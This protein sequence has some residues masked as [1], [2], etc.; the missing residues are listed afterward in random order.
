MQHVLARM[1]MQVLMEISS[2]AP[3]EAK[4]IIV[5]KSCCTAKE[6]T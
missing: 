6:R 5:K 4:N 1:M 3:D 2:S